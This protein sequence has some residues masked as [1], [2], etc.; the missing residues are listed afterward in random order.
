MM[1]PDPK[2]TGL[3]EPATGLNEPATGLNEPT[4]DLIEPAT[5]LNEPAKILAPKIPKYE[6]SYFHFVF[7]SF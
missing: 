6:S 2:A 4:T 3:N 5:G 7:S 1:T